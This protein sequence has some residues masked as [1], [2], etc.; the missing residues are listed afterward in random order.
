MAR[1][2]VL[3]VLALSLCGFVGMAQ[4]KDYFRI[5]RLSYVEGKVSF[6]HTD[7]VEWTAASINMALQPGDRIYTGDNGRAEIEFD[8]GSVL[9][10]AERADVEILTMNEQLIQVKVLIGLCSLTSRGSVQFE[11]AT[12]AAAFTT[13]EKGSYRFDIAENG[14][15]DGIVRKGAM[16][17]VNNKFSRRVISGE[18]LHVPAAEGSTEVLARYDQRDA[19][20]EW[21]D[22][23]NAEAVV[24]ESRRYIA[25]TVYIGMSDLDRYGQWTSIAGYG[26]AW[27]P[28]VSLGWYPYWEGRW[29]YRP[30]WGWT[31]VSYEPWGWLPYHYGRWHY[32]STGWCWLPGPSFSFHFWSPGLVRFYRGDGFVSWIPL[33]PGDYYD[34]NHYHFNHFNRANIYYLNE[35]RLMQRRGPDDLVNRN[36]PGA[37]RTVRTDTFLNGVMGPRTEQSR[38]ADPRQLGRVVTGS[39]DIRPTA[40]SFAPAPGRASDRPSDRSRAVVVRTTPDFRSRGDRY[41]PVTN[42]E[43][44]ARSRADQP[45]ARDM[46]AQPGAG[47]GMAPSRNAPDRAT[48]DRSAPPVRTYQNPQSRSTVNSQGQGTQVVPRSNPQGSQSSNVPSRRVDSPPPATSSSSAGRFDPPPATS[49]SSDVGRSVEPSRQVD[50]PSAPPAVSAPPVSA[51]ATRP[52]DAT[53]PDPPAGAGGAATPVKK[54]PAREVSSGY[55]PRTYQPDRSQPARTAGGSREEVSARTYSAPAAGA[56]GQPRYNG[57]SVRSTESQPRPQGLTQYV[58]PR[59]VPQVS[60][61]ARTAP[62]SST[63]RPAAPQYSAP[64][65]EFT[66]SAP[67]YSAPRQTA[68]PSVQSSAPGG[69]SRSA[70]QFSAPRSAPQ[71]GAASSRPAPQSGRSGSPRRR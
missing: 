45:A 61:G 36:R 34:I 65:R 57:Y 52:P 1:K 27:V 37:F 18:V 41:V 32:A 22:R 12:P 46:R 62:Q 5:A 16:E 51:P 15:S 31:W 43:V 30:L 21:N 56:S 40:Q 7:E 70:P 35:L 6:Q 68:R 26:P 24:T 19:W 54:G 4:S 11:V 58:A 28:S 67:Q 23:R 50:R 66:R 44:T 42:P 13:L 64:A 60:G 9:R 38:V 33:G 8:D 69:A 29:Q 17:A 71:S 14:D 55:M 49:R 3:L 25:D 47:A 59:S 63:P 2:L 53:R 10:M 20:D 39:L 48:Q